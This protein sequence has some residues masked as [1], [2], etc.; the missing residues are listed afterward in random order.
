MHRWRMHFAAR[1]N[2]RSRSWRATRARR[3]L[4]IQ[5]ASSTPG[6]SC[7][8][9]QRTRRTRSFIKRSNESF[10]KSRVN[11]QKEQTTCEES[12]YPMTMSCRNR[13]LSLD[14]PDCP[15]CR[16]CTKVATS[17]QRVRLRSDSAT[18]TTSTTSIA[19]SGASSNR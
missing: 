1:S 4:G 12:L 14:C 7:L 13:N 17:V 19:T 8:Y 18:I 3:D 6:A 2:R 9:H 16:T 10:I 15:D 11:H 5:S